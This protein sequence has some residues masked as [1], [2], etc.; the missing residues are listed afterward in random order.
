[1][2]SYIGKHTASITFP[3]MLCPSI[4][5]VDIQVTDNEIVLLR[6]ADYLSVELFLSYGNGRNVVVDLELE[7]GC[8]CKIHTEAMWQNED[9]SIVFQY[10]CMYVV[11]I[12]QSLLH[13]YDSYDRVAVR[14]LRFALRKPRG[15]VLSSLNCFLQDHEATVI[16][17]NDASR[18]RITIKFD[19][20][21]YLKRTAGW[22]SKIRLFYVMISGLRLYEEEVLCVDEDGHTTAVI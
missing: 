6:P 4:K 17:R 14:E 8:R 5:N 20:P 21:I 1:M 12:D 9:K 10:A 13:D 2:I 11:G 16:A 15:L 22:I 19:R 18:M 7:N 3:D